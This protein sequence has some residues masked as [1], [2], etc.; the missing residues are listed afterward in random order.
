[1]LQFCFGLNVVKSLR[2]RRSNIESTN[3]YDIRNIQSL[4]HAFSVGNKEIFRTVI[5][6]P[7]NILQYLGLI[8]LRMHKICGFAPIPVL[9]DATYIID[10]AFYFFYL[11]YST[12]RLRFERIVEH[13]D[14][15]KYKPK[16]T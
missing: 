15:K 16:L 4:G 12:F 3:I 13:K 5:K 2:A 10:L 14:H 6:K 8:Y 1:M 7:S 11:K 9:G